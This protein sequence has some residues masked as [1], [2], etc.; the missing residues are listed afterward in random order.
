M[1]VARMRMLG[2]GLALAAGTVG[3]GEFANAAQGSPLEQLKESRAVWDGLKASHR[4]GYTY[5]VRND[6]APPFGSVTVIK[7]RDGKVVERRYQEWGRQ[8]AG[9]PPRF[10][11]V[12]HGEEVG[13]NADAAPAITID[14]L[15]QRALKLAKGKLG[16]GERLSMTFDPSGV[17]TSCEVIKAG[18]SAAS[19]ARIGID[20]VVFA[21]TRVQQVAGR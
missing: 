17:M 3:F 16:P 13:S 7:V 4:N 8:P 14:A 9:T 2:L 15:Y 11:W 20:N 18:Q 6:Q 19:H 12:E 21:G 5:S 1:N 10:G